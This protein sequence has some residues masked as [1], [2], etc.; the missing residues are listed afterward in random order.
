MKLLS[1]LLI[2]LF[3]S[4]AT[5]APQPHDPPAPAVTY[6]FHEDS[7]M[8]VYGSSNVRDWT[9]DVLEI[10]G[11]VD[12]QPATDDGL[13]TIDRVL[14][15]VPVDSMLSERGSQNEKAHKALN[16]NR[17]PVIYFRSESITV[18]PGA[19]AT[20]FEATAEGEL[21]LAGERRNVI[22]Q[23]E[24]TRTENGAIR[25]QGEHELLMTDFGIDPPT[26][27]L[28]ALRVTDEIRVA[29]DVTLVPNQ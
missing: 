22:L 12:V 19:D 7:E 9:M 1:T 26:A 18:S 16:K 3:S 21:I 24:G 23:S 13:P 8:T 2:F 17:Q 15:E 20:T 6:T 28:G 4:W 5:T 10:D 14:V 11:Q 27:L 25:L 29:F